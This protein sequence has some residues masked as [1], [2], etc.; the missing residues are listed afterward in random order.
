[1]VRCGSR[2][3]PL[4]RIPH[5]PHVHLD[6]QEPERETRRRS[7]QGLRGRVSRRGGQ[8]WQFDELRRLAGQGE[9][10]LGSCQVGRRGFLER[11]AMKS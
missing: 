10:A 8:V 4:F 5:L 6:P 9:R 1:M 7:H 11:E 3:F 2:P